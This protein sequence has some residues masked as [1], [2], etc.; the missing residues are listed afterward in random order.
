VLLFALAACSSENEQK[1]TVETACTLGT[2]P[3]GIQ[4]CAALFINPDTGLCDPQLSHCPLG[5][6]PKFDEGCIPVGIPDCYPD[7]IDAETGLC[8]PGIDACPEGTLVLPQEG[9][10]SLDPPDG[11]GEAPWGHVVEQSGDIHV[12]PM[13]AGSGSDGS[14][15]QPYTSIHSAMEQV[16]AGGRIILAA[17]DYLESVSLEK[18]IGLIGRC[19]SMVTIHG[20]PESRPKPGACAVGVQG[21]DV[22][23][24]VQDVM[25]RGEGI[26]LLVMLGARVDVRRTHVVD[27]KASGILLSDSGTQLNL[28]QS[29]VAGVKTM[30]FGGLQITHGATATIHRSNLVDNENFGVS[31]VDQGS[32]STITSSVI[33]RTIA[34]SQRGEGSFAPGVHVESGGTVAIT[35]TALTENSVTGLV[36]RGDNAQATLTRSMVSRTGYADSSAEPPPP[37]SIA[38]VWVESGAVAT[39]T[40]TSFL[41]NK[42]FGGLVKGIG[43]SM[44]VEDSLVLRSQPGSQGLFG[45]GL[46]ASNGAQLVVRDSSLVDNNRFGLFADSWYEFCPG[47]TV[48]IENCLISGTKSNE[49]GVMGDGA[50]FNE[51]VEVTITGS[52]LT[53]NEGKGILSVFEDTKV[54]VSDS[55]V[56]RNQDGGVAVYSGAH[57]GAT[58]L[59]IVDNKHNG[60]QVVNA[61]GYFRDGVIQGTI[62]GEGL[63]ADGLLVVAVS[64]GETIFDV[65]GMVFRD[66]ARA[67]MIFSD[68]AGS[69]SQSLV[70]ENAYGFVVQGET[71]PNVGDGLQYIDN[72]QDNGPQGGLPV[73]KSAIDVPFLQEN[74][75]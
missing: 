21:F 74:H 28:E 61:L 37:A 19:A 62:A 15:D 67:G 30:S 39:I 71:T 51:C 35:D 60:M 27:T 24:V 72:D 63:N 64:P 40:G 47:T 13:A 59:A 73:P 57:L 52:N 45:R 9:C 49:N 75:E 50:S 69:V 1:P 56:A 34:V 44:T 42:D 66:N 20:N 31:I 43:A 12:D 6:I 25:I 38:G 5:T 3:V 22:E 41:E 54:T 2:C 29:R 65:E 68:S 36:V 11:C 32:N 7:F 53:D 10:V 4:G 48:L 18:S 46:N 23:V 16:D 70:A 8:D 58:A 33:G 26:G 17:G 14:R 55:H